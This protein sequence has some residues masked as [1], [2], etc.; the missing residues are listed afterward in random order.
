MSRD[1]LQ[2]RLDE[3]GFELVHLR[4]PPKLTLQQL[5]IHRVYAVLASPA[6]M[7]AAALLLRACDDLSGLLDDSILYIIIAIC[8]LLAAFGVA[9]AIEAFV[10]ERR[11]TRYQQRCRE[12]EHTIRDT[13]RALALQDERRGGLTRA[14]EQGPQG[15]LTHAPDDEGPT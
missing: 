10:H 14:S 13:K 11:R 6:L 1:A 5:M 8:S 9:S 3:A 12:L 7:I 2:Q 15:A 4:E